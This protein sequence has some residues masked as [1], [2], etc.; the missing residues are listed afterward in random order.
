MAVQ[1]VGVNFRDVL[2]VLGMY[3]GDP[4]APGGDCA[5]TIAAVPAGSAFSIGDV[6]YGQAGG[7]LGTHVVASA[8]MLAPAPP[9]AS[10]EEAAS[11]PTIFLT[12]LACLSDAAAA[13]AGDRVL[14]HA[15]SGGLGL[16][17]L[18]IA[19]ALNAKVV[20]TAGSPAKRAFL[21]SFSPGVPTVLD[22]RNLTFATDG[23]VL[24]SQPTIVVNS[25]TSP[26]MVAASLAAL[27]LRGSFVEV[28]KR[29]IWSAARAAQERP[30]VRFHTVAVDFMPPAVVGTGLATI[31]QLFS[32]GEIKPLPALMHSLAD[33]SAAM[34]QLSAAR[35]V[36]KVVARAT[37]ELR[38][39][40]TV[41]WVITGGT[42][43]LGA[44]S[45][46][47]LCSLGAKS[48]VLL[49]RTG[50]MKDLGLMCTS[51][52]I[53]LAMADAWLCDN[54]FGSAPA[55]DLVGF[56][57]AGGVVMDATLRRQTASSLRGTL[58]PK[59]AGLQMVG[60]EARVRPVQAV[61]LFS[62]V[63]SALGSGGQANYGAANA[64]LD[65]AA[66]ASQDQVS[67]GIHASEMLMMCCYMRH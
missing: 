59:M 61:K 23:C 52:M 29:D 15:A 16:A 14:V 28:A 47:H 30:D 48:C 26:G 6:V 33:A 36:G 46:H 32:A 20:G 51:A 43:A 37:P 21:R 35:H 1:A 39:P 8:E 54:V 7:C 49:G 4:G 41:S 57:H 38:V 27:S 3:P 55:R 53:T 10:L 65:S 66:S 67:A 44:A 13:G 50:T 12:A 11:L 58:T 42:G 60:S 18:Q 5:G 31:S 17:S 45:A 2:N 63:A 40:S 19:S 25:L 24:N 34:R 9:Q 56:L 62:S 22:S 64:L